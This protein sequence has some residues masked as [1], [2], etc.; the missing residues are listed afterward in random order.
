MLNSALHYFQRVQFDKATSRVYKS[1]AFMSVPDS[2]LMHRFMSGDAEAGS[3]RRERTQTL[4]KELRQV[5]QTLRDRLV[6][7][8]DRVSGRCISSYSQLLSANS[9]QQTTSGI[10]REAVEDLQQ[11]HEASIDPIISQHFRASYTSLA[12]DDSVEA[13]LHAVLTDLASH[14]DDEV[15]ALKK[16]IDK[17]RQDIAE[18]WPNDSPDYEYELASVFMH[19]GGAGSGHYYRMSNESRFARCVVDHAPPTVYQKA[20]PESSTRWLKFND[21]TVRT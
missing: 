4:V 13:P 18:L 5:Q 15:A 12:H 10:L 1:N 3:E 20:L 14:L 7:N 19:S 16:S 8:D 2:L 21:A 6:V 11:L 17:L 9:T